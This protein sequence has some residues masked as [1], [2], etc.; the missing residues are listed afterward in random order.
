MTDF[1]IVLPDIEHVVARF[2]AN[3]DPEDKWGCAKLLASRMKSERLDGPYRLQAWSSRRGWIT[4][5]LPGDPTEKK[6]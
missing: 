1:R 3:V 4:Y 6:S 5:W 2:H